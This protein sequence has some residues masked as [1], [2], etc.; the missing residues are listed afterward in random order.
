MYKIDYKIIK[1]LEH[2]MGN[3]NT[4]LI[5]N[6]TN[7]SEVSSLIQI[8]RGIFQG[9][10][11]SPLLFCISL[12]P[13][14]RLINM[15]KYGYECQKKVFNHLFYMDDLKLFAKND[16]E[17][18]ELLK[19]V[20]SFSDCIGMKFNTKK[21]AK[22]TIKRGKYKSSSNIVVDPETTIKQLDEHDSY[23]YLG[24]SENAG[25]SH[26]KMKAVLRKEYVRRVRMVM[27]SQLNSKNKFEA[28]NSLA[29]PV[30][31]Y[32]YNIINWTK[33]ELL[34]LDTKTRKLLTCNRAHHP[35]A[36]V[37]RLYVKRS[38]GGRGLLQVE[39]TNKIATIGLAK[40]LATTSDWMMLCVQKHESKKKL[41]SVIRKSEEYKKELG[42]E[43][44]PP[45]EATTA[46]LAAKTSKDRAKKCGQDL[47]QRTWE[48]KP[49]HGKFYKRASDADISKDDTF[50]WLKS[51]TLKAETEGFI[52]AAQ[53]QSLKTKNYQANIMKTT[54]DS[55]CRYCADHCETIDH[56]LSGCPVLAKREY[57][58]RHN[59]VAQYVHWAISKHYG[60]QTADTWYE[61]ETP[62]VVENS[63]AVVL[64]DFSI[65][66]DR[67]IPANRPDIVVRD[68]ENKTCLLLDISVPSDT[69]TSLKTFEKISKY[70]DL[71]IE[72][73]RAWKMKTKTIP[74]IV[75][76]LGCINK[77]MKKYIKEIP[78]NVLVNDVQKI[79]LLGTA[80]IL[81][82]ALSMHTV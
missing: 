74:V 19:I 10:S 52:L 45:N 60:L 72:C 23:K 68:K 49:L 66:T 4:N 26:N 58:I 31:M 78:G 16:Q 34:R 79:T 47:L 65:Q 73:E 44:P 61:H 69:N 57:L 71:E 55:R 21:C 42:Y 62:P 39:L 30:L 50:G 36:D 6:H 35:K 24:I 37:H 7:G 56:L 11:L 80:H 54:T 5:L 75:G 48:K 76:A 3:W 38:N 70:K 27:Q 1:F 17:L 32:S 43:E 28:I 12:F 13:L 59:K 33:S 9:D 41:Y 81:R 22:L 64:W 14:S 67:C 46:T 51:S 20:K 29:I 82:K 77:S 40:Y 63:K 53:D 2:S 18:G 25:V 15:H 8:Q